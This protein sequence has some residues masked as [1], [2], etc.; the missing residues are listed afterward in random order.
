[1]RIGI[2]GGTFDPVHQGH[3]ILAEQCREQAGLGRVLF[4]PAARPPHKLERAL[5]PFHHRAEML[6]L[7]VA[8]NPAFR[9]DRLEEDRT[10]PSYTVHTLEI[11]KQRDADAE[12]CL[13]MGSDTLVDLQLWYQP[14]R[15][16]ELAGLAVVVRPGSQVPSVEIL[17]AGLSL[18]ASFDLRM[19]AVRMPLLDISSSSIRARVPLAKTIRY[20]VP[21]SVEMY[22]KE[23]KLYL[24]DAENEKASEG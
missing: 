11:L 8:G 20:E 15:I 4:V 5:T 24:P 10:G 12:L 18:P 17:K 1:M 22:L 7:A 6:E 3:L 21:R 16:L 14:V 9:V 13:I 23:K 19:Q 2:F